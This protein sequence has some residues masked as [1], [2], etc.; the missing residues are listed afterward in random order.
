V[1]QLKPNDAQS[2]YNL[3]NIL[4][5][6]GRWDEAIEHYQHALQF[7]PDY[8]QAHVNLGDAL[9]QKG[10][11]D[12]ALLH[13]QHALQIDPSNAP[14]HVNLGGILLQRGKV[15]DAITQFQ[16]ALQIRPGFAEAH[17]RLGNA[18]RQKGRAQEAIAQFQQSL[19]LEP[20][21]PE[22]Q[23]DLAWILATCPEMS[24]RNG[25]KALQL[26]QRAN[27]LA[28]GR[29]PVI[30]RTLAAAFAEAGR[31]TDAR[32]S[33]QAAIELLQTARHPELADQIKTELKQYEAGLPFHQQAK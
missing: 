2:H 21:D 29:N 17:A 7:D 22:V 26:A 13:F 28:G 30:L 27:K 12:D 20:D 31:F 25:E 23:N 18:L 11:V 19:Q 33:A 4:L 9:L 14:A 32:R 6:N 16:K 15:D 5:Q 24:L 8:A 3:G 10:M 1:L